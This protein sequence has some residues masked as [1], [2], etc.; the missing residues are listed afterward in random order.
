MIYDNI[1]SHKKSQFHPFF[2]RYIFPKTHRAGQFDPPDVLGLRLLTFIE[3]SLMHW[4]LILNMIVHEDFL[5]IDIEFSSMP[6]YVVG[7]P[8]ATFKIG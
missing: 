8:N 7:S 3:I 5:V 1:Q 4:F 6:R 2:R